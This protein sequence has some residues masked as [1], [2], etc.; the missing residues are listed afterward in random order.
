V[1]IK[2]DIADQ[3]VSRAVQRVVGGGEQRVG[4]AALPPLGQQRGRQVR[5]AERHRPVR[6]HQ[7]HLPPQRLGAG[8]RGQVGRGGQLLVGTDQLDVVPAEAVHV[9]AAERH[10]AVRGAA[11]RPAFQQV[12]AGGGQVRERA[13]HGVQPG[14]RADPGGRG[15]RPEPVPRQRPADPVALRAAFLGHRVDDHPPVAV[16]VVPAAVEDT[17]PALVEQPDAAGGE[18]V[19]GLPP[20]AIGGEPALPAHSGEDHPARALPDAENVEQLGQRAHGHPAIVDVAEM[21]AEQVPQ[22]GPRLHEASI[23]GTG[24]GCQHKHERYYVS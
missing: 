19:A 14:V 23:T 17:R 8:Q 18:R 11:Q 21:V 4:A 6:G 2:D 16:P 7:L 1:S 22:D 3:C 9:P 20:V 5:I 10:L 15:Q 13:A 12:H 24:R